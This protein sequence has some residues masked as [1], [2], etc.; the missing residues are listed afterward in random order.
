MLLGQAAYL[1]DF[2]V[3]ARLEGLQ[4]LVENVAEHILCSLTLREHKAASLILDVKENHC[5][6]FEA[7]L[8]DGVILLG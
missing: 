2:A 4:H 7:R 3:L 8:L 1:A 6:L 5:K